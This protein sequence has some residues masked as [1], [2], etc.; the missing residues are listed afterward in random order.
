MSFKKKQ[1]Y[2]LLQINNYFFTIIQNQIKKKTKFSVTCRKLFFQIEKQLL[3]SKDFI[4]S[5]SYSCDVVSGN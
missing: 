3:K 5:E 1:F 4:M 2:A